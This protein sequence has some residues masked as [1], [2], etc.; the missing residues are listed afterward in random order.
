MLIDPSGPFSAHSFLKASDFF[1]VLFYKRICGSSK[2]KI[3][4]LFE[5]PDSL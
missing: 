2:R 1:G 4:N 5:I 3:E